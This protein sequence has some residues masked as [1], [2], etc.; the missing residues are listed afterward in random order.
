MHTNNSDYVA[1]RHFFENQAHQAALE[2][3]EGAISGHLMRLEMALSQS[4]YSCQPDFA[5][6]RMCCVNSLFDVCNRLEW[7][8]ATFSLAVHILDLYAARSPI[9]KARYRMVAFCCLWIAS[10]YNENKPKGKLA[11]ALIRRAG[12]RTAQK[13][14]FLALEA[15][16]LN[17]IGWN[18]SY[19][20]TESFV[21]LFLNKAEPNNIERRYGALFLCELAHFNTAIFHHYS[22][23]AIAASA[24]LLTNVALLNL[25]H[26]H[27]YQ[28]RFGA[29]DTLLLRSVRFMPSAVRYKYVDRD[30]HAQGAHAAQNVQSALGAHY[31]SKAAIIHNLVELADSFAT[32]QRERRRSACGNKPLRAC[33]SPAQDSRRY[34]SLPI[35]PIA[36]PTHAKSAPISP[37]SPRC[38]SA[39]GAPARSACLRRCT[40]PT[41]GSTPT[42]LST[43]GKNYSCTPQ[44]AFTPAHALPLPQLQLQPQ[45]VEIAQPAPV[46]AHYLCQAPL[47]PFPGDATSAPKRRRL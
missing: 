44:M 4:A 19:P 18:L 35:S 5:G 47:R 7:R 38:T 17:C 43:Q 29:L 16:I 25:R 32:E 12:Y 31:S 15:R 8:S 40:I 27:V 13:K 41:P 11:D 26:K 42:A 9:D 34:L 21:D 20:A 46:P 30:A 6:L 24:I 3:Y 10:K 14:L 2:D 1:M 22:A 28:H 23:S 36:S 33:A 37:A 39:Q 45:M